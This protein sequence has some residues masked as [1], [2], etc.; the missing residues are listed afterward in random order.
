MVYMHVKKSYF[1]CIDRGNNVKGAIIWQCR[2]KYDLRY[3]RIDAFVRSAVC[4]LVVYWAIVHP[5]V[6]FILYVPVTKKLTLNVYPRQDT[7]DCSTKT[8]TRY[9]NTGKAL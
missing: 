5:T 9:Q 2:S 6:K 4:K 1:T 8:Q 3:N 7:L